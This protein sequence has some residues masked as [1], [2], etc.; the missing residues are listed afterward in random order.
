MGDGRTAF[1]AGVVGVAALAAVFG[2]SRYA[3]AHPDDYIDETF[4]YQTVERHEAEV[5]SWVEAREARDDSVAGWYT[6]ALEYGLTE[7]WMA[8][9][10]FQAVNDPA[11]HF[12]R[13]RV[14]TRYRF[15]EEG[16]WPVDLATSL[17]YEAEH[18]AT[19]GELEQ[20][21]TPR[22]VISKDIIS[23]VNTTLNLDLPVRIDQGGTVSFAYALGVRYPAR[24][25]FRIGAEVRH[26]VRARIA[27][28]FPQLWLLPSHRVGLVVKVG[29]GVG[30]TQAADPWVARL[31]FELE[32]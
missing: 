8:D 16:T 21:V 10:A 12:G 9:V 25:R 13:L 15:A 20:S 6:A 5:E 14:E 23:S 3:S 4:V 1:R 18:D 22:L 29:L 31:S 24:G 28:V 26:D 19:T 11:L 2:R 27:T 17:E 32:L 30:L 7:R